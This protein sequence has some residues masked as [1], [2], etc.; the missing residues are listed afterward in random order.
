M[1]ENRWLELLLFYKP[2]G[3]KVRSFQ[4]EMGRPILGCEWIEQV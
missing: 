4:N 1:Q 2:I 3:K